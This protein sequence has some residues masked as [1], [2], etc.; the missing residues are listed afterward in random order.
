[1][2][3]E[4]AETQ[5]LQSLQ[6]SLQLPLGCLVFLSECVLQQS[7]FCFFETCFTSFLQ[8]FLLQ[9]RTFAVGVAVKQNNNKN[10]NNIEP[11]VFKK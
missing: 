10:E 2:A 11:S 8:Q 1:M 5:Q 3:E 4:Q 9:A 7:F 6:S